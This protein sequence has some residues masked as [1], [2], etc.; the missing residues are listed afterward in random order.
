VPEP[1]GYLYL[2]GIQGSSVTKGYEGWIP[3]TSVSYGYG[4][5]MRNGPQGFKPPGGP[6]KINLT[7]E[8]DAST[9]A[10]QQAVA[11]GKYFP[12][13]TLV[14][15]NSLTIEMTGVMISSFVLSGSSGGATISFSL[16]IES[17]IQKFYSAP[18]FP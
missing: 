12:K 11:T 8:A 7:M 1:S 6:Q 17:Q 13:A 3:I 14:L 9:V 10:L 16:N 5:T 4:Q 15:K 18:S 2:E